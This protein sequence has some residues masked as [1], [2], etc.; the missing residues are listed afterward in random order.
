VIVAFIAFSYFTGHTERQTNENPLPANIRFDQV[1]PVSS[2]FLQIPH[3]EP[4]ARR[5]DVSSE[6][7]VYITLSTEKKLKARRI[8]LLKN[9]IALVILHG[10]SVTYNSVKVQQMCRKN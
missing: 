3:F 9:S 4:D 5:Y 6:S 7:S 10:V 1:L 2:F 8:A